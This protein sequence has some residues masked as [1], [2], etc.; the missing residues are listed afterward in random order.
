MLGT[1]SRAVH[2]AAPPTWLGLNHGIECQCDALPSHSGW[3]KLRLPMLGSLR[4][5]CLPLVLELPGTLDEHIGAEAAGPTSCPQLLLIRPHHD[6]HCRELFKSSYMDVVMY[7]SR[8]LFSCSQHLA[9]SAGCHTDNETAYLQKLIRN[10][11]NEPA[12]M[13]T[14]AASITRPSSVPTVR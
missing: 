4:L 3:W 12:P 14:K 7:C 13:P 1:D 10:M 2:I 5:P 11:C 6:F 8:P 9:D